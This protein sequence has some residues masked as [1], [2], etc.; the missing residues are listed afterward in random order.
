MSA[1]VRVG[2]IGAGPWAQNVHAPGLAAHPRTTLTTVWARRPEIAG[3]LADAHG[4][5][6][7]SSV[8]KLL[9]QVDAVAFAVPPS[10]QAE[11]AIQAAAAGKHLIVE[12]PL[13]PHV[14]AAEQVVAAVDKAKVA[15]L[16]MLTMRYSA[17]TKAWLQDLA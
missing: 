5:T 17:S 12:K 14:A 9:D 15:A 4:A 7:S 1:P 3:R 13:A 2:L 10:V 8:E 6:V 16:M 11:L